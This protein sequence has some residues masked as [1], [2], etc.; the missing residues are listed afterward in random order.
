VLETEETRSPRADLGP[1]H[2]AHAPPFEKKGKGEKL[3]NGEK[4]EKERGGVL[5]WSLCVD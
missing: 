5:M 2:G 4:R 3:R 1:T